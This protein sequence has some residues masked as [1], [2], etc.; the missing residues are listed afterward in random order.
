MKSAWTIIYTQ[1]RNRRKTEKKKEKNRKSI[2]RQTM[3]TKD[4]AQHT[5]P[6]TTNQREHH[7]GGPT[8]A[9]IVTATPAAS[10]PAMST[11]HRHCPRPA[12]LPRLVHETPQ[13]STA[14]PLLASRCR[15][16]GEV[17]PPAERWKE[18]ALAHGLARTTTRHR[19]CGGQETLLG[20]EQ[21]RRA[22]HPCHAQVSIQTA[23]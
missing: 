1:S 4:K 16:N 13:P 15:F 22:S 20:R 21:Q 2:A 12:R 5:L 19:H 17:P 11:D 23:T 9:L 8:T 10:H 18:E 6:T 3:A 7:R 14:L